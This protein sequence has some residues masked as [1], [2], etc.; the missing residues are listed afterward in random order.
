MGD[1]LLLL[2]QLFLSSKSSHSLIP[3]TGSYKGIFLD[4]SDSLQ[5]STSTTSSHKN[6]VFEI[7]WTLPKH[8][9]SED[10]THFLPTTYKICT[11]SF[12]LFKDVVT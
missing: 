4:S 10:L 5:G 12:L 8:S 1:L 7:T 2:T 3:L 9:L 11:F 6:I